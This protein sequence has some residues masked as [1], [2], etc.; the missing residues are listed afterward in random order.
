MTHMYHLDENV[1]P[2]LQCYEILPTDDEEFQLI[3]AGTS[4][5]W[6]GALKPSSPDTAAPAVSLVGLQDVSQCIDISQPHLESRIS[7]N[8]PCGHSANDIESDGPL[9]IQTVPSLLNATEQTVTPNATVQ[10]SLQCTTSLIAVKKIA[11]QNYPASPGVL[12]LTKPS[13]QQVPELDVGLLGL[14]LQH[15]ETY[16][17]LK[18]CTGCEGHGNGSTSHERNND[19]HFDDYCNCDAHLVPGWDVEE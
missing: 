7:G 10:Q 19:F 4:N 11:D 5:K 9:G 18:A 12:S 1:V 8:N 6:P 17:K 14:L 13:P 3:Q 15:R 16:H 2:D